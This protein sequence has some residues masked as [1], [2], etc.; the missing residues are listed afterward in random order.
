MCKN[1]SLTLKAPIMTAA[2][3][4][5]GNNFFNF[6]KKKV[7][8]YTQQTILM[9]YHALSINFEKAEKFELSSAA[10]LRWRFMG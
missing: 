5:F 8:Y 9:K 4:K 2:E 3:D 6:R 1:H 7:W 10:N